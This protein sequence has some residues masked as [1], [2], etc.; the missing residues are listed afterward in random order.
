M[1]QPKVFKIKVKTT[2][3]VQVE[4]GKALHGVK[5]APKLWYK[6]FDSFMMSCGY[7]RIGSNHCVFIKKY[8]NEDFFIL[9]IYID[10]KLIVCHEASKIKKLKR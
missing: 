1:E 7:T 2:S 4:G 6:K 10:D 8:S 3:C 5:Y 9:L